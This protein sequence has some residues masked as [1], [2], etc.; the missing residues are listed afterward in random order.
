MTTGLR[1]GLYGGAFDP[2][3]NAHVGLARAAVAQLALDRLYV[4]PTGQPWMKQRRLTA[5]EHRLAMARLAF[6]TVPQVQVDDCEMQRQ[7]TT[8]TIDTL[9]ELQQRHAAAGDEDIA[10]Y[11]IMGQ[12]LLHSLPQWQRAEELLRSVT[13][14]VLQRPDAE[15][16]AVEQELAQV[17]RQLPDLRTVQLHLPASDASSTR[18]RAGMHQRMSDNSATRLAWLQS[19]VPPGVAQYIERHQ[20]YLT[21]TP[22]GH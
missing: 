10:W 19:L 8:Y 1:I 7:G 12:D 13:V 3:H 2:P 9:H 17:R 14:A 11:L 21:S 22:D 5:P 15:Q 6:E 16:T 4:I 20:L 18:I